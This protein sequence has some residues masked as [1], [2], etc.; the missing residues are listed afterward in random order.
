MIKRIRITRQHIEKGKREEPKSCPIA[1]ALQKRFPQIS[2]LVCSEFVMFGDE[3]SPLPKN[4]RTFIDRF[5]SRKEVRPFYFWL[6][7]PNNWDGG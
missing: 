6:N 1:L 3:C 2:I 7:V 5:D 4:A